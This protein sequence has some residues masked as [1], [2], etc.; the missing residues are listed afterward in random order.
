MASSSSVAGRAVVAQVGQA[1]KA[2]AQQSMRSA[3]VRKPFGVKAVIGRMF[4]DFQ[5]A[6]PP[7]PDAGLAMFPIF[8]SHG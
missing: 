1:A 5:P 4:Y 2:P 6:G 7:L 3:L 8:E